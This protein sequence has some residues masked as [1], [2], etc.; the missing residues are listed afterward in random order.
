MLK[1]NLETLR[2][3]NVKFRSLNL[4]LSNL[5]SFKQSNVGEHMQRLMENFNREASALQ[6]INSQVYQYNKSSSSNIHELLRT[7]NAIA[8]LQAELAAK[9]TTLESE[10]DE[11][12][13]LRDLE[14]VR[15]TREF[16]ESQTA[17]FRNKTR[18]QMLE[19]IL[20]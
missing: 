1:Q 11:Q 10:Q 3:L 7:Q 20:L 15:K 14:T 12:S 4:Q 13:L 18:L 5:Q 8:K 2:L 17:T 9:R 16:C 6:E 19:A